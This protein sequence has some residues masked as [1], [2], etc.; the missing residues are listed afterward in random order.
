MF[1]FRILF[2]TGV[3]KSSRN[4]VVVAAIKDAQYSLYKILLV[5]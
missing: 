2:E 3:L 1:S 5:A 4:V